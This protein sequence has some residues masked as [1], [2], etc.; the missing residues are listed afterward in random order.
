MDRLIRDKFASSSLYGKLLNACGE[1]SGKA[2]LCTDMLKTVTGGDS[3]EAEFKNLNAFNFE[4]R[5]S[6]IT[7]IFGGFAITAITYFIFIKGL[8]LI[9][10]AKIGC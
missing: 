5:A 1:L 3:V 2:L 4:K 10:E 6:Y 8:K 7:A 9:L